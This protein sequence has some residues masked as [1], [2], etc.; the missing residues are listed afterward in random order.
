MSDS[1]NA[2]LPF[3]TPLFSHKEEVVEPADRNLNEQ[4]HHDDES[5]GM[6]DSKGY[7]CDPFVI[8]SL[9]FLFKCMKRSIESETAESVETTAYI[10]A[11]QYNPGGEEWAKF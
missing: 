1:L 11:F 7:L 2:K 10:D 9:R 6:L 3:T 4:H 5:N 8:P